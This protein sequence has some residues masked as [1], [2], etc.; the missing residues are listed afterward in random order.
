MAY[1]LL[2]EKNSVFLMSKDMEQL[3]L[4]YPAYGIYENNKAG[5]MVSIS[6]EDFIRIQSNEHFNHDGTNLNFLNTHPVI[7]DQAYMQHLISELI[8]KIDSI[9]PK[10]ENTSFGT[11]LAV[12]KT[13]LNNVDTTSFTY[14]YNGSLEK[15]LQDQGNSVI[16]T[17]QMM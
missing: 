9:Y 15:Y 13:L 4:Q 11:D 10:Y 14:P 3:Q 7:F 12:Y 5:K 2:N 17:L 8:K 1:L 16:S 6:N